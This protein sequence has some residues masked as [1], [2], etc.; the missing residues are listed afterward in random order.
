ML[1]GKFLFF[2][3]WL[4]LLMRHN[5]LA[6]LKKFCR[7]KVLLI[8]FLPVALPVI[9]LLVYAKYNFA[10]VYKSLI[11]LDSF[12]FLNQFFFIALRNWVAGWS[13][14]GLLLSVLSTQNLVNFKEPLN[15]QLE[16]HGVF[17]RCVF[18]VILGSSVLSWSSPLDVLS[19]VPHFSELTFH[20]RE[21]F[22]GSDV[23]ISSP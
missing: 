5:W 10:S 18:S 9:F 15:C 16:C 1:A 17:E 12:H 21:Q 14:C 13:V 2:S 22:L 11:T 6:W 20:I 3:N 4:V 8:R 7:L 19:E 23:V